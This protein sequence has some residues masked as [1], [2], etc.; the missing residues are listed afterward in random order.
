MST[1]CKLM[2]IELHPGRVYRIVPGCTEKAIAGKAVVYRRSHEVPSGGPAH[3]V[4]LINTDG[5]CGATWFVRSWLICL[6]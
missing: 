2:P 4:S 1:A 3:E 5:S 6:I